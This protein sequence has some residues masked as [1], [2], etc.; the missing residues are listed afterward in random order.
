MVRSTLA[1][2][3]VPR[4]KPTFLGT[5]AR[6]IHRQEKYVRKDRAV[7]HSNFTYSRLKAVFP[8]VEKAMEA[9]EA[10]GAHLTAIRG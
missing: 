3:C 7:L 2:I 4:M 6:L 5:C 8:W 10:P 9:R 1:K